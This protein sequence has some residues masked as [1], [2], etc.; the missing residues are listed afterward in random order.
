MSLTCITHKYHLSLRI[1]YVTLF[2]LSPAASVESDIPVGE[3][4]WLLTMSIERRRKVHRNQRSENNSLTHSQVSINGARSR[5]KEQPQSRGRESERLLCNWM[6]KFVPL[7]WWTFHSHLACRGRY[8]TH[9]V[10]AALWH[11][12]VAHCKRV[13]VH[14]LS[15]DDVTKYTQTVN[16]VIAPSLTI[17]VP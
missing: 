16:T 10:V 1:G 15:L 13:Y 4:N 9:T 7:F 5:H 6:C 8:I 14:S 3:D 2:P 11:L 12:N 17:A